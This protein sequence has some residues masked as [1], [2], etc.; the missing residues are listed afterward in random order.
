MG[1]KE[2]SRVICS[3]PQDKNSL[4]PFENALPSC[5]RFGND[6]ILLHKNSVEAPTARLKNPD[7][8]FLF[9]FYSAVRR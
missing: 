1:F 8:L 6:F 4:P 2:D 9:V 7:V 5:I 3:Y